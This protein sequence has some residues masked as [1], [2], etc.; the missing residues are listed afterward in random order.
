MSIIYSIL[1]VAGPR[2]ALR[3]IIYSIIASF[4][5]MW[6]ALVIQKVLLCEYSGCN[7]G[8]QV[9]IAQLISQ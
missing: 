4:A 2:N 1:R 7:V 3:W 8:S 9:A 6:I 5:V